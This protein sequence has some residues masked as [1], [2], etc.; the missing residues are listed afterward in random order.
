MLF[1]CSPYTIPNYKG[2]LSVKQVI[3]FFF[4]FRKVI[5]AFRAINTKKD[6]LKIKIKKQFRD[7]V[8]LHLGID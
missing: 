5:A 7:I 1:K 3:L 6:Q 8:A 2:F 4:F